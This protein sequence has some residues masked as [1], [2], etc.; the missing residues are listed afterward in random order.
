MNL[1]KGLYFPRQSV[2]IHVYCASNSVIS[3]LIVGKIVS[4]KF[5]QIHRYIIHTNGIKMLTI[6]ELFFAQ[7]SSLRPGVIFAD[8]L[9]VTACFR[10]EHPDMVEL[11]Y[12]RQLRFNVENLLV[13]FRSRRARLLRHPK[14]QSFSTFWSASS[15]I[16]STTFTIGSCSSNAVAIVS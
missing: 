1:S 3:F 5:H 10:S 12:V 16:S 13:G 6:A 9:T 14:R 8:F 7:H 15:S 11:L 2:A 4:H